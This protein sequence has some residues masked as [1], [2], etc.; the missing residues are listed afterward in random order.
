MSRRGNKNALKHGL[1]SKSKKKHADSPSP[2]PPGEIMFVLDDVISRI[3]KRLEDKKIGNDEFSRL[4]NSLSAACVSY[5]TG[6]RTI[7]FISGKVVP[8]DQ[9]LSELASLDFDE[10]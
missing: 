2:R 7:A 8:V 4:A 5:F 3:H 1:Y 10:D 6:H 9:A